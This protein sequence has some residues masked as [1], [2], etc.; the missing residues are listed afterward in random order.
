MKKITKKAINKAL[1]R[2]DILHRFYIL[3]G[4]TGAIAPNQQ[5]FSGAWVYIKD[6][7]LEFSHYGYGDAFAYKLAHPE[8]G[9]RV[10]DVSDI[11][12]S[13][14]DWNSYDYTTRQDV[15]DGIY[16]RVNG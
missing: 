9:A 4:E 15:V 7:E 8:N 6:G 16:E 13:W 5:I 14:L 11:I 3:R 12:E 2:K 10:Y 1:T